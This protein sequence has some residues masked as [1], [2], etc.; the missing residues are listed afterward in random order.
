MTQ[1]TDS[2]QVLVAEDDFLVRKKTVHILKKN[3]YRVVGE[4]GTGQE[5]VDMA[6]SLKPDIILM[7]IKMPDLDGLEATRLL[8]ER[9]PTPVVILSA[10]ET[11]DLVAKASSVG[12]GAYL[13]KPLRADE[14]GR[15]IAIAIARHK[16]LLELIK[17]NQEL[18]YKNHDLEQAMA[19]IKTLQGILPICSFC[20]KIRDDKGY[21]NQLEQYLSSHSKILF[22]HS[23]CNDCMEEHYPEL[24][25]DNS[26]EKK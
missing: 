26:N 10:H 15:A 17:L 20:K 22:S 2:I 5:A 19:E 12:A 8:Q 18:T 3:G 7:D 21:W 1:T 11:M 6:G 14:V 9:Y 16:D 13:T 24:S 4:A 23:V 25:D